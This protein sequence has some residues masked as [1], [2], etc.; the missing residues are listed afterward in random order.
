MA[1][2]HSSYHKARSFAK[3]G[4]CPSKSCSTRSIG[5][6]F[7]ICVARA[8]GDASFP[9]EVLHLRDTGSELCRRPV[10]IRDAVIN[11]ED[12]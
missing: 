6:F 10:V 3:I 7:S 1:G 5:G 9:E 4:N 11:D 8:T 2:T 12:Q